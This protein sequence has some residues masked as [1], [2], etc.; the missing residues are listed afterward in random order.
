MMDV[1][2]KLIRFIG[3]DNTTKCNFNS[4]IIGN[5]SYLVIDFIDDKSI[6]FNKIIDTIIKH[7]INFY[8]F[9]SYYE[10]EN[11]M[12][13]LEFNEEKYVFIIIG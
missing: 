2:N 10:F 4:F 3:L 6:I 13:Y 1:L 12:D 5:R 11:N 9:R 8:W 7:N